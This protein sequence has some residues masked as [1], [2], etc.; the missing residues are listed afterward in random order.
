MHGR[1]EGSD[2]DD[3]LTCGCGPRLGGAGLSLLGI[4]SP[5]INCCDG[6]RTDVVMSSAVVSKKRN[7][8]K[9][10][11]DLHRIEVIEKARIRR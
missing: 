3:G 7:Q 2:H 10:D 5:E 11:D 4:G 6:D 8:M 1:P 9:E